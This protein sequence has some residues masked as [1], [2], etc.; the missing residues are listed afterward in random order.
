MSFR[1]NT[2]TM[3]DFARVYGQMN[4]AKI[5]SS[6]EKLST[7]LRIN[8]AADDKQKNINNI[9]GNIKILSIAGKETYTMWYRFSSFIKQKIIFFVNGDISNLEM[10]PHSDN[11]SKNYKCSISLENLY[12]ACHL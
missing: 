4:Q 1:I 9:K 3:G 11:C 10:I 6:L 2:N 12:V 8:I 5:D 7:G